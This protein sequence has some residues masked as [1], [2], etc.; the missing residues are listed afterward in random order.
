MAFTPTPV[1]TPNIPN[2]RSYDVNY[3]EPTK[4]LGATNYSST[5][6][7]PVASNLNY[8]PYK[9][10]AYTPAPVTQVNN[11]RSL[12]TSSGSGYSLPETQIQSPTDPFGGGPSEMDTINNEFSS[13]NSYLD[14]QEGLAK[15]NNSEYT[16]LLTE[17][18]GNQ[19]KAYNDQQQLETEGV[20]KTESL[21]LAKVRQM[22]SDL[23]QG[24]AART[25]I[26]GGG[27]SAGEALSE[28]FGR[29]A[30]E[31]MGGV[32]ENA[33]NAI[34]RVNQFYQQKKSEL[35][36]RFNASILE[37][38]QNL[39]QNLMAISGERMKSASAKQAATLSTWKDYYSRVNEAK[40]AAQNYQTQLDMWNK[41]NTAAWAPV[42]AF[43]E[44]NAANYNA[45]NQAPLD[46]GNYRGA[47]LNLATQSYNPQFNKFFTPLKKTGE[48][49]EPLFSGGGGGGGGAF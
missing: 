8:T 49:E 21:N 43:N 46:P 37:A 45:S 24:N 11:T 20:K 30:Q 13:W 3:R 29:R 22:L 26:T 40:V 4:V 5:S 6:S 41:Q 23:Q 25:A 10:A 33:N 14:Q 27:S 32:M 9:A 36:D 2:N 42:A 47:G 7:G 18:K 44:T 39:D 34:N 31:G 48:E 12:N 15:Q 1:P 19:E 35:T 38:K 16:N 28:R 17:Q